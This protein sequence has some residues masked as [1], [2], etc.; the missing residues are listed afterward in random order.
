M[1][2]KMGKG[3]DFDFAIY[4]ADTEEGTLALCSSPSETLEVGERGRA[5]G[6]GK[7][8]SVSRVRNEVVVAHVVSASFVG[9][10]LSSTRVRGPSPFATLLRRA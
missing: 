9:E 3:I 4:N 1:E 7:E 8:G 10:A 5:V 6:L 2:N